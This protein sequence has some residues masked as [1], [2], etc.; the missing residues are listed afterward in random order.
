MFSE[1]WL[2][3]YVVD[4]GLRAQ[5][6]QV[7]GLHTVSRAEFDARQSLFALP[8]KTELSPSGT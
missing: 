3:I 5:T 4:I 8:V 6:N 1:W 2:K 7:Q